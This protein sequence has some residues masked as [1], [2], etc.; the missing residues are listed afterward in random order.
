MIRLYDVSIRTRIYL[1]SFAALAGLIAVL[2][3][4][5]SRLEQTMRDDSRV[6]AQHLVDAA[7]SILASYAAKER[8]G[9]FSRTEAQAAALAVLGDIRYGANGAFWIDDLSSGQRPAPL[10]SPA[11]GEEIDHQRSRAIRSAEAVQAEGAG[12]ITYEGPPA[13]TAAAPTQAYVRLFEPWGWVVGTNVYADSIAGTIRRTIIERTALVSLVAV[14][15]VLLSIML[16]GSIVGPLMV[17]ATRMRALAAGD[18]TSPIP[19]AHRRDEIGQMAK[20]LLVFREALRNNVALRKARDEATAADAAKSEF[21]ANMSHELRTPLNSIVGFAALLEESE[22]LRGEERRYA[23]LVRTASETLLEIVN[24]LI[25]Y[26]KLGAGSVA[27]ELEDFRPSSLVSD[28]VALMQ[29][30]AAKKG[31]VLTTEYFGP[32]DIRLRGDVGRIR[33]VLLN[34]LGNAVKFTE[35][36]QVRVRATTRLLTERKRVRL[37]IDITDTGIGIPPEHMHQLFNRFFQ[38]DGSTSRRHGGAGLGLPISKAL[39]ELMEGTLGVSS[40]PGVG[41][42]FWFEL[43]GAASTEPFAAGGP[44]DHSAVASSARV[45]VV[46]DVEVNRELVALLLRRCGCQVD[47]ASG[48]AAAVEATATGDYDLVLMDVHMPEMDGVEATRLMRSAGVDLP[49]VAMTADILPERIAACLASGMTDYLAKPINP[50]QLRRMVVRCRPDKTL[51]GRAPASCRPD[52]GALD[53][54]LGGAAVRSLLDKFEARLRGSFATTGAPLDREGLRSQAH[55]LRGAAGM[56]G[57]PA[58]SDACAEL[59]RACVQ[60]QALAGVLAKARAARD[61][62]LEVLGDWREAA[63]DAAEAQSPPAPKAGGTISSGKGDISR[64]N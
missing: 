61:A 43:E 16:G 32:Q 30:E 19:H 39:V 7:E 59:E 18:E 34:L 13:S 52:R 22:R 2:V 9:E 26:S 53:R 31:L 15:F 40:V 23:R 4:T 29:G 47:E 20:A 28:T 6:S 49:I 48:G 27:L 58:V 56:L 44:D 55:A 8:S 33:Q 37:R 63:P 12:F 45:L 51:A 25:D 46:D 14:L 21:L 42:T 35:H 62:A 54:E 64:V 10:F 11:G 24:E 57:F 1:L 41:S 36:G 60:N 50:A 38:V 17:I 5:I 3:L